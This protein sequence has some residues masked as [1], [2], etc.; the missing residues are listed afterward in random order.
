MRE[1]FDYGRRKGSRLGQRDLT[2]GW[3]RKSWEQYGGEMVK[4]RA[5]S[6]PVSV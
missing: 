1:L 2:G 6:L 5:E 4:W 3:D